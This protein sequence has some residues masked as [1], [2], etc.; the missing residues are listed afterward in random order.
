MTGANAGIGKEITAGLAARGARV[1]MVCRH[2]GRGDAAL[3]ELRERIPGADLELVLADL[4]RLSSVRALVGEVERRT[5]RLDVLVSNAGVFHARRRV[6]GDGFEE[7]FAVN[8]LAPFV[9]TRGL[10]GL[11]RRSAPARVVVVASAAHYR[12]TI[13]FD[14]LQL[15]RNYGGWRAYCQSKLANVLFAA[16]LARRLPAADVTV[17]SVH[18]GTVA[19]KLLLRGIVP[20]WLARPFT[21]TPEQGARTPLY[22]AAE[23]ELAGVTGRYFDDRRPKQPSSEAQDEDVAARLWAASEVLAN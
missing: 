12:G 20:K 21:R 14:D 22:V 2:R 9:L 7:T 19:T 16:E 23:P 10:L 6:T 18:P 5:D 4:S 13:A 1:L 8:H 3:Y 17:N 11:L 15:E